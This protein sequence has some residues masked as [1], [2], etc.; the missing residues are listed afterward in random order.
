MTA[1]N[2]NQGKKK[3]AIVTG[4]SSSIG[5]ETSLTLSRNPFLTYATMR[6]VKK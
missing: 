6:N 4:S 3:V 2:D 1:N 5:V